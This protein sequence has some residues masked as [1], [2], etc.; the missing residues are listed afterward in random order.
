MDKAALCKRLNQAFDFLRDRGVFHTVSEAAERSE[1][2]QPHLSSAL[3]GDENRLT[4]GFMSRFAKAY[5]DYI[6]EDW[7]LTGEGKLE[8]PGRD[9]RPHI[10][11]K[12]AAGFLHG[13]AE[14]EYGGDMR[15]VIPFL[16]HYDFT[17]GVEGESMLPDYKDG[18]IL[19]CRISHDRLNPPVGKVCVIDSKDGAAVK[20]IAAIKDSAIVCHSLNPDYRDYEVEFSNINQIAVV[21]GAVRDIY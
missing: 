4:K 7:L 20:E 17:I 2:R 19:A 8:K 21:V 5:S 13:I 14:G 11:A 16:R 12:A 15:P 1:I 6:N 3:K 18:D 9:M 10:E